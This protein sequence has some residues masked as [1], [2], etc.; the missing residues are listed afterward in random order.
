[1]F[2]PNLMN[3]KS[4]D[5]VLEIGP[6]A[7]PFWR[8]DCLADKF[9]PNDEGVDLKQFG[10]KKMDVSGKPLFKIVDDKLP[11]KDK[12]FDY[13][14][15]SHVL[16]HV[17]YQSL[18]NLLSEM[19]RVGKRIY[20]EFP[21]LTYDY[22]YDFNVHENF[23]D[24]VGDEIICL[25]KSRSG[26]AK[27]NLY[28]EFMM[29]LRMSQAFAVERNYPEICIV[30]KE[31]VNKLKLSIVENE[32]EFFKR[33]SINYKQ[34]KTSSMPGFIFKCENRI[35]QAFRKLKKEKSKTDFQHLL[36]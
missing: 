35:G 21:T 17:P 26:I 1:M 12:S 32:V 23:M 36:Q 34:K 29:N 7:Y 8:S 11:F 15:C 2:F 30:G 4:T 10:G 28:T 33:I 25:P 14:I 20:L 9:D 16:E 31:F 13:I 27:V 3:I 18:P 22:I 6:G 5:L 24:I 19:E